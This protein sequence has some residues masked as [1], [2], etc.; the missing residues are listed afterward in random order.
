MELAAAAEE[1]GADSLS[2]ATTSYTPASWPSAWAPV[3]T[4]SRSSHSPLPPSPLPGQAGT[5]VLV[6]GYLDP[7]VTAKQL[8]TIDWL[9]Q[10]RSTSG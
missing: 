1:L 6:L 8:A 7:F 10:G 4:T 9:S 2:V 3:T 5:S